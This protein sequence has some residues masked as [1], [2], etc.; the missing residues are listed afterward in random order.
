MQLKEMTDAPPLAL[1]LAGPLDAPQ[2]SWRSRS[3]LDWLLPHLA[4]RRPVVALP[5]S[6]PELTPPSV[7]LPA[8]GDAEAPSSS[9]TTAGEGSPASNLE[10]AFEIFGTIMGEMGRSDKKKDRQKEEEPP[11]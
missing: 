7:L 4:P 9:P 8:D 10:K 2:L 5:R 6:A 11:S 3:F 1:R